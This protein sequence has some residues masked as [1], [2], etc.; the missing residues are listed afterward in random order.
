MLTEKQYKEKWKDELLDLP[1]Y[2]K[3][4]AISRRIDFERYEFSAHHATHVSKFIEKFA[5]ITKDA[6]H[7]GKPLKLDPWQ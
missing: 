6:E 3:E 4:H 5:T 1:K 7:S 2:A